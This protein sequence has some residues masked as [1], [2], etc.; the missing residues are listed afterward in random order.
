MIDKTDNT[1]AALAIILAAVSP[2][3]GDFA[4]IA[5]AAVFG[6]FVA[7]TRLKQ[8][9]KWL[10]AAFIFRSVSIT[11]FSAGAVAKLLDA[12]I[13]GYRLEY[14]FQTLAFLAFWIAL[15]G[16]GWFKV[17]DALLSRWTK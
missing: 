3:L 10:T 5:C 8:P 9:S 13:A 16:D 14:S 6:A 4:I 1:A 15:V 17:K 11:T 7:A 2:L 12:G